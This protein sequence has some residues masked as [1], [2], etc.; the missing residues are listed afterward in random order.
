MGIIKHYHDTSTASTNELIHYEAAAKNQDD[1]VLDFF[2]RN[3]G[4][5]YTPFELRDRLIETGVIDARVPLTSIRR[6]ITYATK[7]G[8]LVKCERGRV[9]RLGRGNHVWRLAYRY[10]QTKLF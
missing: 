4:V 7:K 6:A 10:Q 8:D 1:I 3:P 2:R 5:E 9:E